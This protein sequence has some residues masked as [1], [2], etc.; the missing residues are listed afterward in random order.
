MKCR[1]IQSELLSFLIEGKGETIPEACES[2][3]QTCD[4]C[5]AEW[6]RLQGWMNLLRPDETWTPENDFL[7]RL[8]ETAM[9]EKRRASLTE[10]TVRDLGLRNPQ[11]WFRRFTLTPRFSYAAL[12]MMVVSLPVAFFLFNAVQRI[13][14]V[15][16]LSGNVLVQNTSAAGGAIGESLSRNAALQT[17]KDAEVILTLKGGTEVLVASMS[18]MVLSDARTVKLDRGCAYFDIP[19]G[20]GRFQVITPDGTV[21]VLGTAFSVNVGKEESVVTVLDGVV[22]VMAGTQ[23]LR[24]ARGFE[25]VFN[26]QA[27]AS[28][29]RAEL[30]RQMVRW[31]SSLRIKRNEDELRRYYP[32][33]AGPG[34]PA[35]GKK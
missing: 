25:G 20:Q 28:S 35:K 22:Q 23:N 2:H 5:R 26:R 32:S 29:R 4:H 7:D 13:G 9:Q 16:Y 15:E 31:I 1:V 24:V 11:P 34:S 17:A 3:L 10:S 12:L 8:V 6:H 30:N 33:L 18:R 27:Q 21:Q 19:K 14:S